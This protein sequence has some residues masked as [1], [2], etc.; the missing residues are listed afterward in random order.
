MLNG[1]HPSRAD[2]APGTAK[3]NAP[4]A[5][6]AGP[7]IEISWASTALLPFEGEH[8]GKKWK[9]EGKWPGTSGVRKSR[10]A[11]TCV[12]YRGLRAL[13][14]EINDHG[15]AGYRA[16]VM[17]KPR[18]GLDLTKLQPR[19]G[20]Q[21]I[22]APLWFMVFDFDGLKSESGDLSRPKDFNEA[23]VLKAAL[24]LLPPA[25]ARVECLLLA[26]ASTGFERDSKGNP[27][28]GCA[29]F[30]LVFLLDRPLTLA[31]Q[32]IVAAALGKLPGFVKFNGQE[33]GSV[34][35]TQ[36]Y[37]RGHFVFT[38][39]PKLPAGMKDPI[40]EPARVFMG[41]PCVN[42][43]ELIAQLKLKGQIEALGA[44]RA[45][46]SVTDKVSDATTFADAGGATSGAS[47]PM[48]PSE[49]QGAPQAAPAARQTPQADALDAPLGVSKQLGG[50][51]RA[52]I[53][54]PERRVGIVRQVVEA[55]PNDLDRTDWLH[56]AHAIDGA[57]E[58]D[59]EGQEIFLD[60]SSRLAG[61][62]DPAEDERV[63]DTRGEGRSGVGYLMQLVEKQGTP[64]AEKAIIA[65]RQGEAAVRFNDG[66]DVA[67]ALTQEIA[68]RRGGTAWARWRVA[69]DRLRRAV[70]RPN[71]AAGG[72][73][74]DPD[75]GTF[76][77]DP[78]YT[79]PVSIK[80]QISD[81]LTRG[82]VSMVAAAPNIGKSTYLGA[83]ALA[84]AT[85]NGALIGQAKLDWCGDALIV[86]NEESR[87]SVIGRWRGQ[88]RTSGL[89]GKDIKHKL[90]VFAGKNRLRIARLENGAVVPTDDGVRFVEALAARAEKDRATAFI[91]M[92]TLV[93]LFEGLDE[94]SG[95]HMDKAIGLL[96]DIAEAGFAAIDVM[97]HTGKA[98]PGETT[99][100]YRGSSAIFAAVAEMSTLVLLPPDDVKRFKLPPD[101]AARTLRLM[102][103]RQRDGAIP[104]TWYFEREVVSLAAS[105]PRDPR[106]LAVKPVAT[107]K[108]IPLLVAPGVDRDEA[109]RAL[110]DAHRAGRELRRGGLAGKRHADHGAI[111]IDGALDC[112]VAAAET[113]LS[114]LI[115]AGRVL[116]T[117]RQIK[118]KDVVFIE[119]EEIP[120]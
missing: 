75:D 90:R 74:E 51:P 25:F 15:Q 89:A 49:A 33:R 13:A 11:F 6:A 66:I 85:E 95:P 102:G 84:V 80:P 103:Q 21:F 60:F 18:G 19:N 109:L 47:R 37:S 50:W 97:H 48:S 44:S 23:R 42:V 82:A 119:P 118:G 79:G 45:A 26:T 65:V 104:G 113:A 115:E 91:G 99:L 2:A 63:W 10:Y 39:R 106:A 41:K 94:N 110:W 31:Q 88:M 27:A 43:G 46:G 32:K 86:S 92:D 105:D 40:D 77:F 111:V 100:S 114:D 36:I 87:D 117:K 8:I 120:Y 93:S 72:W 34:I 24:A 30:R 73:T 3:H 14:E 17:G 54:P 59:P 35:D 52:L 29:R 69:L 61:G 116:E 78:A 64:E 56:M 70:R 22:D 58:G 12:G 107:L 4:K 76:E 98:S 81:R 67:V 62:S 68:D 5:S 55:I 20:E 71:F 108:A 9:P 57:L 38:A 16:M 112:G 96:A 28:N 101:R 1:V 83:E 53:A 7:L